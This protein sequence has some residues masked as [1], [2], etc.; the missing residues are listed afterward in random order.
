MHTRFLAVLFFLFAAVSSFSQSKSK[1][2]EYTVDLTTVQEDRVRVELIPPTIREKEIT[3]YMPKIIPG[4]YAIADYGR[5]V[6]EIE[7]TDKKGNKLPVERIDV[8]SW[9]IKNANKAA[10]ISY[11]VDDSF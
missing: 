2:Y 1:K 4:T 10:K 5:Y 7:V 3:F 8:N 11:W 6:K 9:K